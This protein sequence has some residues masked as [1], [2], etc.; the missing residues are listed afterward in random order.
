MI[1]GKER[2]IPR[3][4][5]F[6][7]MCSPS[8]FSLVE[9]NTI[10]HLEQLYH[11]DL[12]LCAK[13]YGQ[14]KKPP[15]DERLRH[16]QWVP[17]M[18]N[19]IHPSKLSEY[20]K[21]QSDKRTLEVREPPTSTLTPATLRTHGFHDSSTDATV[22]HLGAESSAFPSLGEL[23]EVQEEE[24]VLVHSFL[25][26]QPQIDALPSGRAD[27]EDHISKELH[28]IDRPRVDKLAA[29]GRLSRKNDRRQHI[30]PVSPRTGRA[31]PERP[32]NS[33]YSA[34][35]R[36]APCMT[37]GPS[38]KNGILKMRKIQRSGVDSDGQHSTLRAGKDAASSLALATRATES[39]HQ[40]ATA[41]R[42]GTG[43]GTPLLAQVAPL[44]AQRRSRGERHKDDEVVVEDMS[45]PHSDRWSAASVEE[46]DSEKLDANDAVS[47][48][49][50]ASGNRNS[51]VLS[52]V[53]GH[54]SNEHVRTRFDVSSKDVERHGSEISTRQIEKHLTQHQTSDGL[55]DGNG[56]DLK[57]CQDVQKSV[58]P[59]VALRTE[60]RQAWDGSMED[61]EVHDAGRG[62]QTR[63]SSTE[64]ANAR[65]NK[66]VASAA[67][68]TPIRVLPRGSTEFPMSQSKKGGLEEHTKTSMISPTRWDGQH[69]GPPRPD[70]SSKKTDG[71]K[72]STSAVAKTS[73]ATAAAK[74][75][76]PLAFQPKMRRGRSE[77]NLSISSARMDGQSPMSLPSSEERNAS[78]ASTVRAAA[79][80]REEALTQTSVSPWE[81][82]NTRHDES[83]GRRRVGADDLTAKLAT[84]LNMGGKIQG[85]V[86]KGGEASAPGLRPSGEGGASLQQLAQSPNPQQRRLPSPQSQQQHGQV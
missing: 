6:A 17:L 49:D 7:R 28:W 82:Y 86:N 38:P 45:E 32:G 72:S 47:G 29:A 51:H 66:V 69:S 50:S 79:D 19:T 9:H 48:G 10:L 52:H 3:R 60:E 4:Q 18:P 67:M 2:S 33:S 71:Q 56:W 12:R 73:G 16:D 63:T 20:R 80:N 54:A 21:H 14:G 8:Q 5:A 77:G 40:P 22:G 58:L 84:K 57:G 24:I 53:E 65:E 30:I 39:D 83:E 61:E 37:S 59:K 81:A 62:G 43:G 78:Q 1:S 42:A 44:L 15:E 46:G 25:N 55:Q 35:S 68:T 74:G 31:V 13:W 41:E 36:D 26:S 85:Q 11:L 23:S 34:L 27:Y 76:A 70:S 64:R 75:S